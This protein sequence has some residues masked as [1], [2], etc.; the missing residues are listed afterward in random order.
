MPPGVHSFQMSASHCSATAAVR[1]SSMASPSTP[2]LVLL[3]A[4]FFLSPPFAVIATSRQIV[5]AMLKTLRLRS[6]TQRWPSH[7]CHWPHFAV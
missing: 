4:I 1:W 5:R 2:I 3:L 7:R 6:S